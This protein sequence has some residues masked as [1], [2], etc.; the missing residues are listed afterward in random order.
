MTGNRRFAGTLS[1][2]IVS[3]LSERV[4]VVGCSVC[5]LVLYEYV[6]PTH[7]NVDACHHFYCLKL[8]LR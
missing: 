1:V 7:T 6:E 5:V 8:A 3:V 2:P 4:G